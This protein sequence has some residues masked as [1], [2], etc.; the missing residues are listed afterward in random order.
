MTFKFFTNGN[1]FSLDLS[2]PIS[3]ELLS[4]GKSIVHFA[5]LF[6]LLPFHLSSQS[7]PCR[8]NGFYIQNLTID[9]SEIK[10]GGPPR[11]G[12]PSIDNPEFT[13]TDNAKHVFKSDY[14]LGVFYNGIAK[15][16]PVRIMDW[17]EVV[18][19]K[20]GAEPVAVTYCP[21]C[22]SGMSFIRRIENRGKTFGISGLLYNSDVL[23]FDRQTNSLWSQILGEAIS[24]PEVGRKLEYIPTVF[25]TWINWQEMY[26]NTLVLT[27]NTG[28]MRNYFNS[29]YENYEFEPTLMFKPKYTSKVFKN[30]ERIIGIEINDKYKAYAF[31]KLKK[32]PQPVKDTFE[33]VEILIHYDK[34]SRSAIAERVD[35]KPLN[36]VRLFWFA[37]Y[38]FHPETEIFG[39]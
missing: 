25:T 13:T 26:P 39:N 36:S 12:I 31:S 24:G 22:G 37:W 33:G 9:C 1:R 2:V 3:K 5:L 17:H 15:A 32:L 35:G 21:L 18:N 34:K 38:G 7:E 11:D 8:K 4:K 30:K 20:F 29:P 23:L 19:D 10:G 14:V 6:C 16:Y 28:T 27:Q